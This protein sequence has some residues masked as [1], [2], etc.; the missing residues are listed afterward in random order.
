MISAWMADL[1]FEGHLANRV[2]QAWVYRAAPQ[3]GSATRQRLD[4]ILRAS[5]GGF[6][7]GSLCQHVAQGGGARE[8]EQCGVCAPVCAGLPVRWSDDGSRPCRPCSM[9]L[10]GWR[11]T[12]APRASLAVDRSGRWSSNH[13]W[14][15]R[16][17]SLIELAGPVGPAFFSAALPWQS[18]GRREAH[19]PQRA[20]PHRMAFI[21]CQR[22]GAER[23]E[24][25]RFP[26][27]RGQ[28]LLDRL[29]RTGWIGE[30]ETRLAE[31]E[32]TH[33]A[34]QGGCAHGTTCSV[35]MTPNRDLSDTALRHR[36]HD[37]RNIF[38]LPL[39]GVSA[40][41]GACTE[42]AA[43]HCESR[44]AV[45]EFRYEWIEPRVVAHRAVYQHQRR[46]VAVDPHGERCAISRPDIEP[47]RPAHSTHCRP[48]N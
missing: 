39:D 10:I 9:P 48:A 30:A 24:D 28:R 32:L 6:T 13:D 34:R 15:A 27:A 1:H 25:R 37:G 16:R 14:R 23:H 46:P 8:S 4:H 31:D 2:L 7:A 22:E 3:E 35:R 43:I 40:G 45:P 42:T 5:L 19:R 17:W 47:T 26:I 41:V 29:D 38:E 11:V 33:V 20:E 21:L 44:H 36:V 12:F 18:R